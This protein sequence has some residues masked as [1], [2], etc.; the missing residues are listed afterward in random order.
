[1]FS[2]CWNLKGER[3]QVWTLRTEGMK[4]VSVPHW[5]FYTELFTSRLYTYMTWKCLNWNISFDLGFSFFSFLPCGWK[6]HLNY[7]RYPTAKTNGH[8][9]LSAGLL[10]TW[11]Q[12]ADP[13]LLSLP[14]SILALC[15]L[16]DL[17]IISIIL[18]TARWAFVLCWCVHSRYG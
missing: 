9:L 1:M 17:H 11:R 2:C 14:L 15:A 5:T 16:F 3:W 4:D 12:D 13:M 6:Y 10:C 18:C 7:Q 8:L